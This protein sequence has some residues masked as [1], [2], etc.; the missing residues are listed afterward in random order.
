MIDAGT[1]DP[2]ER[3]LVEGAGG[4][5]KQH[6]LQAESLLRAR[7]EQATRD[8]SLLRLMNLLQKSSSF[9]CGHR[10]RG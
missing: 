4:R 5:R 9:L 2:Y 7:S 1:E 6:D 8:Q 3:V 10:L